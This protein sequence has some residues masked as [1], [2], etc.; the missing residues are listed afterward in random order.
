M[1]T[2]HL[3]YVLA[4]ARKQ[5]MTKAA[6]ELYVS[7]SSLSQYIAKLEQELGTA[8][9]ERT[10]NKLILTAAGELYVEA[11]KKV[12]QIKKNLYQEIQSVHNKGHITLGVTSQLGLKMLTVIIPQVKEAYPE[13][14][15]EITEGTLTQ[16]VGML[17]EENLDC[18][19]MAIA[20]MKALL[21]DSVTILGEEEIL[22]AVP[23]SH[24]FARRHPQ[25]AISWDMMFDE[26]KNENFLLSKRGS[27]LREC[28]DRIFL[29]Y[30]FIPNTMFETNS[31]QTMQAM[32]AMG[33]GVTFLGR[34]CA[35]DEGKI[36]YYS[37]IPQTTRNFIYAERK[38]W[39]L[40][41][42]EKLLKELIF[43]YF[44]NPAVTHLLKG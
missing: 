14:T 10:H 6:E 42:V 35:E 34:S 41:D 8:L 26:L 36:R 43:S 13:V 33:I 31:V 9:F 20:D 24:P 22:L 23:R 5:N 3:E 38:N 28:I 39:N 7:Q 30:E 4:I 27:T 44:S 32:V 18:A 17:Q 1:D 12:L 16:L 2:R 25:A 29:D 40:Y 11:A 21:L 19:V 37:L 15:I